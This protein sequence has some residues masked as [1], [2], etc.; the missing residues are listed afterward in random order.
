MI[1]GFI[2]S[3][4]DFLEEENVR[5]GGKHNYAEIR[6]KKTML[7]HTESSQSLSGA[8]TFLASLNVAKCHKGAYQKACDEVIYSI[9]NMK[10]FNQLL[11]YA[12]VAL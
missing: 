12:F 5:S 7:L 11:F 3:Q 9:G 6:E 2:R 1:N 4:Q 8:I 10:I